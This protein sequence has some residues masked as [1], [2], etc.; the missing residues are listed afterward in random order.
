M[1]DHKENKGKHSFQSTHFIGFSEVSK[2]LYKSARQQFDA[3]QHFQLLKVITYS[4][5]KKPCVA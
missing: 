4:S 3:N 5:F 1:K 2:A